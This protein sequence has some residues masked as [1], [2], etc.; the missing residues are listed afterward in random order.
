MV[1]GGEEARGKFENNVEASCGDCLSTE[2]IREKVGQVLIAS[3]NSVEEK[4]NQSAISKD[5]NPQRYLSKAFNVPHTSPGCLEEERRIDKAL[6]R[7][8]N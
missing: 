4:R 7:E 2:Q 8:K 5:E 3:A 1:K 6:R